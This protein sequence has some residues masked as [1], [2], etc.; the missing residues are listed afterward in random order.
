MA[1]LNLSLLSTPMGPKQIIHIV[2]VFVLPRKSL[3]M[4]CDPGSQWTT[5]YD[6]LSILAVT[7]VSILNKGLDCVFLESKYIFILRA[8]SRSVIT[9]NSNKHVLSFLSASYFFYASYC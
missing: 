7:V 8:K 9:V 3:D 2:D 5:R 1:S 4:N 6:K